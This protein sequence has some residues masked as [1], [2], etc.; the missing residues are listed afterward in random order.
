MYV[1]VLIACAQISPEQLCHFHEQLSKQVTTQITYVSERLFAHV[2]ETCI[3]KGASA[4]DK[5]LTLR[6]Y[7]PR[8][9]EMTVSRNVMA[10]CFYRCVICNVTT[11]SLH[12]M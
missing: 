2:Y 4:L 8:V 3:I 12:Q 7:V 1:R 11:E 9:R 10:M 6:Y 5:K